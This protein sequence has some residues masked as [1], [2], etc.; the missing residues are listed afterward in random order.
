[1]LLARL[2]LLLARRPWIYWCAIGVV[3]ALAAWAVTTAVQDAQRE[4]RR[5]GAARTVWITDRAIGRGE[6]ISAT[7]RRAPVALVPDDAV[8]SPPSAL[9]AHPLGRGQIVVAGDVA[10]SPPSRDHHVVISVDR[11]HAPAVLPGDRVTLIGG[12]A[13][14]CLGTVDRVGD[15]AIDVTVA[16]ECAVRASTHVLAGDLFVARGP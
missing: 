2:R 5:W 9:A 14:L 16:S 10:R 7:A 8:A 11:S 1:M 12:G 3:A 6:P 4:Q 13:V 15:Q